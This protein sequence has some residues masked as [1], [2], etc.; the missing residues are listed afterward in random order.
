ME[1]KIETAKAFASFLRILEDDFIWRNLVFTVITRHVK[2]LSRHTRNE[3]T[4]IEST[5]ARL[6][7]VS[8][9]LY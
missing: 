4:V 8:S 9:L 2:G 3:A 1:K 5:L 7:S 6:D